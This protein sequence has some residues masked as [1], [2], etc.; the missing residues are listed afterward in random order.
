MEKEKTKMTPT[1]ADQIAAIIEKT[2]AQRDKELAKL[3]A[4]AKSLLL[5]VDRIHSQ[6]SALVT[7]LAVFCSRDEINQP[8]GTAPAPKP[9]RK[10]KASDLQRDA[11][12]HA[13]AT[14]TPYSI[15]EINRIAGNLGPKIAGAALRQLVAEGRAVEGPRGKYKA[16]EQPKAQEV[17]P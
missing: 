16:V 12:F 6:T 9:E 7:D 1:V 17:S 2:S 14:H 10:V 3:S 4:R 15:S 13:L 5:D 8:N 11:V